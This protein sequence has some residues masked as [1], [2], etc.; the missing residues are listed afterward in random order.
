MAEDRR[1]VKV[2]YFWIGNLYIIEGVLK[3]V[4]SSEIVIEED[5]FGDWRIPFAD[6]KEW[7]IKRI[8]NWRNEVVYECS[9]IGNS[10]GDPFS[11]Q[12]RKIKI[13]F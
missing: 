7:A 6:G 2:E 1:Y 12:W 5:R 4:S 11:N 13:N 8:R 10:Y 3:K 9:Q